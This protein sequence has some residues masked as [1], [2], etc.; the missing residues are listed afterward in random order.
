MKNINRIC[1]FIA[2]S[3][4][5]AAQTSIRIDQ[6]KS[7]FYGFVTGPYQQRN[8][9][10][11][12]LQNSSRIESLI[13]AGNLYLTAQD[14]IAL[15]IENNIDI[16]IQ[17]YGPLLSREVIRRAQGGYALRNVGVNIFS[18]PQSVSLAGITI[19]GLGGGGAGISSGGGITAALGPTIPILD[20]QVAFQAWFG[21]TTSPLSNTVLS[22]TSYLINDYRNFLAQYSEY[23]LPGTYVQLTFSSSRSLVNSPAQLLNPATTGSLDLQIL[24]PLLQGFG[25]SVNSRYI[26][27]AKNNAKDT[28][29]QLKQQVMTTVAAVMNLYWDLVSFREDMRLKE[30]ALATAQKLNEDNKK[31]VEIGTAAPIEVSRSDAEVQAREEDLVTSQT[32]VLQQEIVLKAALSRRGL[33][34]PLLQEVHVIPLDRI[35]VPATEQLPPVNQLVGEALAQRPDLLK[36]KTD[37]E[38][39]LISLNGIKNSLKPTL[40]AFAEFTNHAL[41]GPPNPLNVGNLNGEPDPYYIGGYGSLLGQIF[42]RNFP[43]YSIG[44]SMNIALRNRAAQADYATDQLNLRQ[45][46]LQLQRSINQV[47]A[48]VRVAVVGLQQAHARYDAAVKARTLAEKN[49]SNEQLN[50]QYGNSSVALVIQA[51]RD[52]VTAQTEEVQ[53]MANYTHARIA[54][55]QALG[56]TLDTYHISLDEA[57]AGKMA[58]PSSIPPDIPFRDISTEVPRENR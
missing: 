14:V 58:R 50:F 4:S 13:H 9:P 43:D 26:R 33:E 48:D 51:Q 21:H 19:S 23:F 41:A 34:D 38:S 49:L 54:L 52:I 55:D 20:P 36:Q 28:E 8:V 7:H 32:N 46:E 1:C 44:L 35:E 10:Q 5:L 57:A 2:F 27:I 40:Q 25:R 3:A 12:N 31:Q 53:A 29:L 22:E 16:E 18:G 6:P 17:R 42:R 39:N 11:A 15:T 45:A 56:A 47:D 30:Q 24:Q 37:I